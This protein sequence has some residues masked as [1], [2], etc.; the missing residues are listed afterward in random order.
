[1]PGAALRKFRALPLAAR[2]V[3]GPFNAGPLDDRRDVIGPL[4]E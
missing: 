2:A 3:L 4:R 1:M